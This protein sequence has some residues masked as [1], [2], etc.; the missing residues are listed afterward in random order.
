MIVTDQNERV[1]EWVASRIPNSQWHQYQAIG[2]EKN[3]ELVAGVV[4][5]A[6]VENARCSIH[7]AGDGKRWLNRE[8][9][10][11]VFDYVFRQL[12]CQ[13]VINTVDSDNEDSARFTA[14]L[15]FKQACTIP[16]G[17]GNSDLLIFTMD[18]DSCKWRE[19]K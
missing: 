1:G 11:V 19:R 6:Y 4:I 9:L 17:S 5:E 2:L 10:F 12:N 13:V 16:N 15:G 14:H 8:F 3:G 18:K 7:C